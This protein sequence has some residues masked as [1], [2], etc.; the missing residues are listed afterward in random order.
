MNYFKVTVFDP[1]TNDRRYAYAALS[2]FYQDGVAIE[3]L[4]PSVIERICSDHIASGE[5]KVKCIKARH[6]DVDWTS[7]VVGTMKRLIFL[8]SITKLNQ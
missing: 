2:E 8:V 1:K 5:Y 4:T 6:Q 3:Y 7:P